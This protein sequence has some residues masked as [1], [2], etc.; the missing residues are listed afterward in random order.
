M[1][2][3]QLPCGLHKFSFFLFLFSFFFS[4]GFGQNI[5]ESAGTYSGL[6]LRFPV[7]AK[8]SSLAE[9]YTALGADINALY[10]NPA[11]LPRLSDANI[12]LNHSEWFEDIRFDNI[13]FGYK[14]TPELGIGLGV[15]Y[16]WMPEIVGRDADGNETG[17]ITVS[18]SIVNFGA[19]YKIHPAFYLGLGMKYFNDKLAGYSASGV[20]FDMGLF[21]YTMVQGLTIGFSAQNLGG[22]IQ[23]DVEKEQIPHLFR[24]G[25]AYKLP[26]EDIR[27]ALD[28]TKS[29]E[30]EVAMNLGVQ[31][32]FQ[33]QFALRIGNRFQ[34]G[35]LLTPTFGVGFTLQKRYS[36]DYGFNYFEDLGGIHQAGLAFLLDIPPVSK[37]REVVSLDQKLALLVPPSKVMYEIAG[38][39]L[40]LSWTE[41]YGAQYNVYARTTPTGDWVRL[42]KEPLEKTNMELKAGTSQKTYF[43]TVTAIKDGKESRYA[44]E[45]QIDAN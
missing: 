27:F 31:Y 41:V 16:L 13:A 18:T 37:G 19:G 33:D 25:A 44:K 20:A 29:A 39:R 38:E 4:L 6:F 28:M 17:N 7:S 14:P 2:K 35:K 15:S 22:E 21:M 12:T 10:Y 36:I 23:Y 8:A 24:V 26:G 11:A 5:S 45:V 34:D 1:K 32:V 30:E 3:K 40:I 9:S 43:F 42:N